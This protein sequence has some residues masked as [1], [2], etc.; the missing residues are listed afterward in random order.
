MD[1]KNL[2]NE[3]FDII[4]V[5]GQSNAEG[6]G[7]GFYGNEI[8]DPNVLQLQELSM[9]YSEDFSQFFCENEYYIS[10]AKERVNDCFK[11]ADMSEKFANSYLSNGFLS[12]KRKILIIKAAVGGSGFNRKQWGVGNGLYNRLVDMTNFALSLNSENKIVAFLW[13][14]GEHDAFENPSMTTD[15]RYD[16]YYHNLK[17]MFEDFIKRFQKFDFPI[18][19]GE[20]VNEWADKNKEACD[21]VENA[22]RSLCLENSRFAFVS[23]E[24]LLSNNQKVKNGDEIHFCRESIYELADRYFNE[25]QKNRNI[26]KEQ[27]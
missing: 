14:Q 16:F 20:F 12:E 5:A 27:I 4:I 1:N 11:R 18:I 8:I 3:K 26:K 25:F 6:H 9:N 21:A 22:T 15:E 19:C 24:G 23:S 17:Q 10:V 7:L 2:Y 13:H